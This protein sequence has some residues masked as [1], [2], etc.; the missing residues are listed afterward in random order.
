M[1]EKTEAAHQVAVGVYGVMKSRYRN[2]PGAI[3]AINFR[4]RASNSA[5][6]TDSAV[7]NITLT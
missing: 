4:V 2:D 7:Q 5:G 6:T 3:A 1:Y